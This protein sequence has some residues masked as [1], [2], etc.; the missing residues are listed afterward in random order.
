MSTLG[1]VSPWSLYSTL[2][3]VEDV[4]KIEEQDIE[5]EEHKVV[6]ELEKVE[7]EE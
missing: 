5:M 7:V 1:L 4:E 6:E 3:E 2:T